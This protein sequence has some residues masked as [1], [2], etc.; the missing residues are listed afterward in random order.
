MNYMDWHTKPEP[1]ACDS[2]KFASYATGRDVT[3]GSN[4][5]RQRY[6]VSLK[7][8]IHSAGRQVCDTWE[9]RSEVP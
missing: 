9:G 3:Y 4:C 5:Y 6:C 8:G 1:S 2:C 7:L